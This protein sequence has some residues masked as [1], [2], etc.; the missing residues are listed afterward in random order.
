MSGPI[1]KLIGLSK[2]WLLRYTRDAEKLLS[3][4]INDKEVE[5]E[6]INVEE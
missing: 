3:A 2:A 4:P 6:E 1:R 5:E